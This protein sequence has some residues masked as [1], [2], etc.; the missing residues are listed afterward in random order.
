LKKTAL[1]AAF[2]NKTVPELADVNNVAIT[3]R[4]SLGKAA[5]LE[6]RATLQLIF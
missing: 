4:P 2:S 3:K 1:E 5:A 6:L